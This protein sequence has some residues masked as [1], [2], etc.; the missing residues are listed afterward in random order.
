MHTFKWENMLVPC[1]CVIQD[2]EETTYSKDLILDTISQND[3]IKRGNWKICKKPLM[4]F[5]GLLW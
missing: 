5:G 2:I 3:V 1:H 4:S